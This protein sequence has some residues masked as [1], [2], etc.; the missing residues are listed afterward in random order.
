MPMTVKYI[1]K[2]TMRE[3]RVDE[4]YVFID[5]RV[6]RYADVTV[7]LGKRLVQE[8]DFE[9]ISEL[10]D[11]EAEAADAAQDQ[12]AEGDAS[13]EATGQEATEQPDSADP[14][15]PRKPRQR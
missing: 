13:G 7:K 10:P 4:G 5:T 12:Q 15:P 14:K 11:P 1:G 2:S 8:P 3:I 6:S 9:S